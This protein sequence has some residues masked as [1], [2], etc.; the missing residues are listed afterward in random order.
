MYDITALGEILIDFTYQGIS[1]NGQKL[2]AQN[3][4]GAP[5]NALTSAARFGA[6]TAF[7][8]KAGMDMHGRFLK[9]ILE[10]EQ[11]DTRGFI[12][13]ER[14]FTTLAFVDLSPEGERTFS[15]AR[16]P[17]ADTQITEK[18]LDMKILGNTKIFHVGSLSLTSEPAR[19]TTFAAIKAAKSAGAV[20]SYDPN[21][22]ATLWENV[23]TAKRE[24]KSLIPFV[25]IMKIS[26]EE[27]ELLTD[28]KEPEQAA[29]V[30]LEKG[31]KL[32]AVTLGKDGS[33]IANAK[34]GK[35]VPG[36][37]SNVVDTTG[38]GDA[39]WPLYQFVHHLTQEGK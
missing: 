37:E 35:R 30:L 15:F 12:L 13:D 25:D 31:V 16:K 36:F 33:Y 14:Y 39:F 1:R 26:D 29:K 32:V 24:M 10:K 4:G 2:F 34:G 6:K 5:A 9:E 21:Y 28:E 19:S 8:G 11:I 23:E 27:T 38:A 17:G 20:I 22:R 7:L 18:E 3:P